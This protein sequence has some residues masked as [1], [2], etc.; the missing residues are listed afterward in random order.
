MSQQNGPRVLVVDDD[1]SITD[2]LADLLETEGYKVVVFNSSKD[3]LYL[4]RQFLPDVLLLD[5]MMPEIDGYDV[6]RFFKSDPLLQ[7]T[8]II[9]LTARDSLDARLTCYRAGA[10][11]FLP[12]PFDLEE[13]RLVVSGSIRV[14]QTWEQLLADA[15]K[16]SM[17][18]P[19]AEC[20]S[21]MYMEKR[22]H[23]EIRRVDRHEHPLSL[24]LI[25]LDRL[26]SVNTRHG[27]D[28]GNRVLG[29][30]AE[31][32]RKGIRDSDILGRYQ[33][34]AFLVILPETPADGAKAA[35]ARITRLLEALTFPEKKRFTMDSTIVHNT[36]LNGGKPEVVLANLEERLRKAQQRKLGKKS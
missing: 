14:K 18:D 27:F 15:Q 35:V 1:Q 25:D 4:A 6:C 26:E 23:D 30:V 7:R 21:W 28:F 13:L 20:Y 22:V 16:Q 10:D 3:V 8:R 34:D 9:V 12:K 11:H 29:S 33:Q 31:A 32:V 36:V 5:I 17:M 24:I 19:V 2:L